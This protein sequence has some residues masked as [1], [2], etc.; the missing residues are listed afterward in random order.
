M[1]HKKLKIDIFWL[2]LK[3]FFPARLFGNG[4]LK[5][6]ESNETEF[7]PKNEYCVGFASSRVSDSDGVVTFSVPV[8][9]ICVQHDPEKEVKVGRK[10]IFGPVLAT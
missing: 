7:A 3:L 10:L 2:F 9:E 5:V 6:E 4:T 8:F 1:L